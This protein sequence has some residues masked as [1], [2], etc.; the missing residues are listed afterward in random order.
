MAIKFIHGH[1]LQFEVSCKSVSQE[2]GPCTWSHQRVMTNKEVQKDPLFLIFG[3]RCVVPSRL[4]LL[5]IIINYP[6]SWPAV[7]MITIMYIHWDFLLIRSHEQHN[8]KIWDM[9]KKDF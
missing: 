7:Y 8:I 6:A 3:G 5:D 2:D 4:I 1:P 9:T